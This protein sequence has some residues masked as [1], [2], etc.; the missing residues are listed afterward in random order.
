MVFAR[1]EDGTLRMC[2][3]YW[4]FNCVALKKNNVIP[5]IDELL[6]RLYGAWIFSCVDLCLVYHQVGVELKSVEETV[7]RTI[8]EYFEFLAM[9]FAHTN[10]PA[11][12]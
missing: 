4:A 7:S 2:I 1:R 5:R 11:T 3:N 8:F 10:A 12:F 6:D 9:P